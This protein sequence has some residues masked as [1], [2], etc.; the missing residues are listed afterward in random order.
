MQTDNLAVGLRRECVCVCV[1]VCKSVCVAFVFMPVYTEGNWR[2][3]L[4]AEWIISALPGYCCSAASL[5]H[6]LP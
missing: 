1:G 2:W 5:R 3:E 6:T 4:T